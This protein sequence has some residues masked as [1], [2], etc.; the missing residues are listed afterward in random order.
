MYKKVIP[1]SGLLMVDDVLAVQTCSK[2][3]EINATVNA[4]MELKKLTLGE[5]KCARIHVGKTNNACPE[6]K[7]HN[8]KM[9]DS[10]KEVNF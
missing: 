5:D 1:V 9:K 2:S 10:T 7:V 4:F 6:L 8:N 3:V